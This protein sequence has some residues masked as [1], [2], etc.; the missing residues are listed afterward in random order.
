MV[1]L[2]ESLDE[3]E[4]VRAVLPSAV[5]LWINAYKDAPD[6]YSAREI[7][8]LEQVDP[9]FRLN[10][11]RH[12]SLDRQC[13]AG[14]TAVSVDG[15]GNL[16]RCHF[17]GQV[18]GNIYDANWQS[19]LTQRT[20]PNATCGCYIGYMLMPHLQHERL[21]GEGMLARIPKT[22]LWTEAAPRQDA[23][24]LVGALLLNQESTPLELRR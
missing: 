2:R 4:A 23:L 16:R 18:I 20:C 7:S 21:F 5:Y 9:L 13:S 24:R 17:V 22:A 10:N 11:T 15:E 12:V 1:G 14:E 3:I 6:Y 8:R 19:A